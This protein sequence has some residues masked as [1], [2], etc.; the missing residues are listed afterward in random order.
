MISTMCHSEKGKTMQIGGCQRLGEREVWI[1][2]QS[3][4]KMVCMVSQRWMH[5]LKSNWH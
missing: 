4:V 3:T 2:K 5:L 1:N